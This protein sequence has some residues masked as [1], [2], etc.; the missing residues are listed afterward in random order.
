MAY[1]FEY[2]GSPKTHQRIVPGNNACGTLATSYY[3]TEWTVDFTSGGNTTETKVGD[4]IVG[5][6]SAVTAQVITMAATGTS[7]TTGDMAGTMRLRSAF[8]ATT[9][10]PTWTSAENWKVAGGTNEGTLTLLPKIGQARDL[11][12]FPKGQPAKC[13][14][15]TVLTNTA[16]VCIDGSTPNQTALV[17]FPMKDGSS[18]LL[19]DM[20]EIIN[21][22]CIDYVASSASV[23]NI[24]YFF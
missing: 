24:D 1:H 20:E 18:I 23:V 2:W 16:L 19:R 3:Y 13:A 11:Y 14:L 15:V 7:W 6:S 5:A 17:G 9:I 21:F 12:A 4:W 8:H 22:K 10:T